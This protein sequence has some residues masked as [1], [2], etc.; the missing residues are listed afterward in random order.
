MDFPI[1]ISD[2]LQ[3]RPHGEEVTSAWQGSQAGLHEMPGFLLE[4]GGCGTA[5]G[6]CATAFASI[7][8]CQ[9]PPHRHLLHLAILGWGKASKGWA[10]LVSCMSS[11]VPFPG[12]LPWL[13]AG[14]G[15]G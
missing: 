7:S 15:E 6:G 13:L 1:C 9:D 4:E 12:C 5:T 14:S 2:N 3:R 8:Q 11:V 10:E